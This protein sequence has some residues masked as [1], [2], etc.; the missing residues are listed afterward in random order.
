M[1]HRHLWSLL[2]IVPARST[3]DHQIHLAAADLSKQFLAGRRE[4]TAGR[5][6][7]R[8]SL[9]SSSYH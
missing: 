1:V 6:Y 9:I 7:R 8:V 4:D 3:N 5:A 2:N